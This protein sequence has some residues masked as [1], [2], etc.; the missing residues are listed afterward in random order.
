MIPNLSDKTNALVLSY[1]GIR[2][3]IGVSGFLLPI[4]LGPVGWLFFGID[5]QDNI[6][7]YYHT[8]LR[9]IF[10]GTMCS[11]GIFLFCYR[12]YDR[13]ESWTAN[14][15][16]VS[17]LG[18]A[19][20]PLDPNSDPLYQKS[21]IGYLHS[22]SGGVFFLTLATYSLFHF[23]SSKANNREME[24]HEAE[25]NF[26]Y[27]ASGVVIL[28]SMAA[29]GGYLFLISPEWKRTL[30]EYNFLF[31]MEWIA[32]WAFASAWLTKGRTIIAD[33]AVD[34]MAIPHQLLMKRVK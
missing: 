28:L 32:V 34:L 5:F 11:I 14:L 22:I 16:C 3:A 17:A 2:R 15:G 27:R 7:S 6:S 19:L 13:I 23:P 10:V 33:I 25:R 24:P 12:G 18:V 1:M 8:G 4:V 31:W 9:D 21:L 26:V 30:N 29:M 20:F